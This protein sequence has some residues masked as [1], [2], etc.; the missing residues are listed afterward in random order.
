MSS[1]H[2]TKGFQ[3]EELVLS[4]QYYS[5]GWQEEGRVSPQPAQG[6]G[7]RGGGVVTTLPLRV[8]RG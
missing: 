6:D 2:S 7:Q 8:P 5:L 3:K 4:S 1:H